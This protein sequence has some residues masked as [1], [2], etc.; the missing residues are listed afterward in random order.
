MRCILISSPRPAALCRCRWDVY[1][2]FL[3]AER[4][5]CPAGRP[6]DW[7]GERD[8]RRRLDHVRRTQT[9]FNPYGAQL[10]GV[11]QRIPRSLNCRKLQTDATW[12]PT[13]PFQSGLC[14]AGKSRTKI[15]LAAG[16]LLSKQPCGFFCQ[17]PTLCNVY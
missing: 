14:S 7:T 15:S 11:R 17:C 2:A 10:G 8:I 6:L 1:L 4:V 3:T 12:Q 16:A 5:C 13:C 9:R